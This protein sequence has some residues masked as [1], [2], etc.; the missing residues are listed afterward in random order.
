MSA[1]NSNI[2]NNIRLVS[3]AL[4]EIVVTETT[5]IVLLRRKKSFIQHQKNL[6]QSYSIRRKSFKPNINRGTR[7]V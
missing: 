6:K 4:V 3:T 1:L 7:E 2:E 5:T